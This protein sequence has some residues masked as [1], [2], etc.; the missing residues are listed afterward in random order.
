M[1]LVRKCTEPSPNRKFTASRM[2]AIKR[3][4]VPERVVG[5]GRMRHVAVA[6][7]Q[8]LVEVR[9]VVGGAVACVG[10]GGGRGIGGCPG[11]R[12]H[13]GRTSSSRDGTGPGAGRMSTATFA[14]DDGV[15]HPVRDV[16]ER[17]LAVAIEQAVSRQASLSSRSV[18]V[19]GRS[20]VAA[21]LIV[22]AGVSKA[23][24]PAIAAEIIAVGHRGNGVREIAVVN[25]NV[26]GIG[27]R[28]TEVNA[29]RCLGYLR[30]DSGP[31]RLAEIDLAINGT[32]FHVGEYEGRPAPARPDVIVRSA[33]RVRIAVDIAWGK[34]AFRVVI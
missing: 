18:S 6:E 12:C 33:G 13:P 1:P 15:A 8:S 29:Q 10:G 9:I 24:H 25:W 5:I 14:D 30:V 17:I 31:H 27:V 34:L 32:L 19:L 23:F 4:G 3:V 7:D 20:A 22:S 16:R 11:L 2:H 26:V 28:R 21:R